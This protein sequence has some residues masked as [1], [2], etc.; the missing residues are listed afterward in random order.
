MTIRYIIYYSYTQNTFSVYYIFFL[1]YDFLFFL[2]YD[3]R[4]FLLYWFRFFLLYSFRFFLLY[5]F[6]IL[7]PSVTG[8]GWMESIIIFIAI[9]RL[10][11]FSFDSRKISNLLIKNEG[12]AC[13]SVCSNSEEK[14]K[15]TNS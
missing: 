8:G 12:I 4:F 11:L 10:V 3:F 1:I 13:W 7:P 5:S 2:I 6:L 9:S 15:T 14:K